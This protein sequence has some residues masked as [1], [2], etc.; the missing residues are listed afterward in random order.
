MLLGRQPAG[1]DSAWPARANLADSL[2]ASQVP[3]ALRLLVLLGAGVV[4]Q[5]LHLV[6]TAAWCLGPSLGQCLPPSC[7]R[8]LIISRSDSGRGDLRASRKF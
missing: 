3:H 1:G 7:N 2:Q 5:A 6:Q 4:L 8:G